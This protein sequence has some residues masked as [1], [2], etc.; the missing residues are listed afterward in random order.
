M[1]PGLVGVSLVQRVARVDGDVLRLLA[2]LLQPGQVLAVAFDLDLRLDRLF[3]IVGQGLVTVDGLHQA[4]DI[5]GELEL[6]LIPQQGPGAQED[7]GVVDV[8]PGGVLEVRRGLAP[9]PG[10]VQPGL[11]V[12]LGASASDV[13]VQA[14][15]ALQQ[16]VHRGQVAEHEVE[17]NVQGLLGHLRCHQQRPRRSLA[18][19]A[20]GR[21]HLALALGALV[22]R[23]AR[24]EQQQGGRF[25]QLLAQ[26]AVELLRPLHGVDDQRTTAAA[27]QQVESGFGQG[28]QAFPQRGELDGGLV[29]SLEG[30]ALHLAARRQQQ[31]RVGLLGDARGVHRPGPQQLVAPGGRQGGAHQHHRAAHGLEPAQQDDDQAVGVGVVGVHLVQHHHP[32]GQAPETDEV[33][34]DVEHAEQRLVDGADAVRREQRASAL[35]EPGGGGEAFLRVFGDAAQALDVVVQG[36]AA[37]HQL[38]VQRALAEGVEKG[39]GT[40]EQ[41]V[42]GGLGG[43]GNV[44]PTVL[45]GGLQAQVGKEGEL[46]LAL[47]HGRL[48]QQQGGLVH[49]V[50]QAVT[51]PLQGARVEIIAA[52]DAAQGGIGIQLFG[53]KA[54]VR[55][56]ADPCKGGTGALTGIGVVGAEVIEAALTQGEPVRVGGDP[57]GGAGEPGQPVDGGQRQALGTGPPLGREQAPERAEHFAPR[58]DPSGRFGRRGAVLHFGGLEVVAMVG[59]D[60]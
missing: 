9:Q 28:L 49:P 47:A 10:D 26:V 21:Q 42:A 56:P 31:A 37:V 34:L 60:G 58:G 2:L 59:A 38:Q 27:R 24:V 7:V 46:G 6:R 30:L 44:E 1:P 39:A 8:A 19:G 51:G 50:Q 52:D 54:A 13:P 23:E 29:A 43:Q 16:Q 48:H 18:R 25:P 14:A 4:V 20:E 12:A 53:D 57:V 11:L 33:M 32:V 55:L 36:G 22:G 40:L 15:G 35:G 45:V 41:G 5:T 3:K 17:I